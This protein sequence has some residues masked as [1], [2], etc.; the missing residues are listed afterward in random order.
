MGWVFGGFI[1]VVVIE[2]IIR[3]LEGYEPTEQKPRRK[4]R[5]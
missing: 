3:V 1:M 5:R 4:A 2:L